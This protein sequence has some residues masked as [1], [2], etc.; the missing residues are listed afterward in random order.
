MYDVNL[1]LLENNDSYVLYI[2]E[3]EEISKFLA[4]IGANKG[5]MNFEDVRVTREIKII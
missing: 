5:V 4:L 2:K 1:K 3:G